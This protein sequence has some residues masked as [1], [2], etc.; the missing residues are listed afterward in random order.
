MSEVIR[1][2][3]WDGGLQKFASACGHKGELK[4]YLLL[5]VYEAPLRQGVAEFERHKANVNK[6]CTPFHGEKFWL[7][8]TSLREPDNKDEVSRYSATA[9]IYIHGYVG[10]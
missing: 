5:A 4:H 9:L 1:D 8:A 7:W 6:E 2:L 10:L 3:L